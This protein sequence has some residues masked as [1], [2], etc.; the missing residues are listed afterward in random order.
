MGLL[1][2]DVTRL[3]GEIN[4][5]RRARG[6][7]LKDLVKET[8][9]R[10]LAVSETQAAFAFARTALARRTKADL[11][12]FIS[13]L[14]C[15]VGSFRRELNADLAGARRAWKPAVLAL[16]KQSVEV[17]LRPEKKGKRK[18]A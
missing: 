16:G 4:A 11:S 5:L 17:P 12:G 3:C 15:G 8:R 2:A 9:D 6:T 7:F 10:K 13:G 18:S 1:T 14:R